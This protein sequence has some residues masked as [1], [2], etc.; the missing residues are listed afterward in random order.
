M[1]TNKILP[2]ALTLFFMMTRGC[3]CPAPT[4]IS[5]TPTQGPGGTIVEVQFDQGGL[6]GTVLWDGSGVT[7]RNAHIVG[8]SHT[9]RFTVPVG[10]TTGNHAVSVQSASKLSNSVDFTV[11][12][13]GNNS[14]PQI[15]GFD[16]AEAGKELTLYG[17]NFTTNSVILVDNV[18]VTSYV[19]TSQ[20]WRTI[21]YEFADNVIVC[22]V[23]GTV[24]P[25]T[26]H[27]AKVVNAPGFESA[28]FTFTVPSRTL[29]TAYTSIAGVPLPQYY[30]SR[31][32]QV[33]SVRR[34]YAE[35]GMA[36]NIVV[37]DTSVTKPAVGGAG[38]TFTDADLYS[39]WR[40]YADT[41]NTGW[42]MLALYADQYSGPGTTW[43]S[44]FMNVS[45]IPGLPAG[46]ERRGYV[47]FRNAFTAA[48]FGTQ[49]EQAYDRDI[50]H[51][52][53]HAFNLFH[54]DTVGS[55]GV[56]AMARSVDLIAAKWNMQYST[57]SKGHIGTHQAVDVEPGQNA[58]G[59]RSC[60]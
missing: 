40:A 13:P 34:S 45:N 29:T 5:I 59:T 55:F 41:A 6:G 8:L 56:S 10:A 2:L 46:R 19:G 4:V 44:M 30:V 22:T 18:T 52:S 14:V 26:S 42:Y 37:H 12:G 3:D 53:G 27:T 24:N 16:V 54:T 57:M 1:K 48:W 7:T 36:L 47:L 11:T 35:A 49:I 9:L 28:I 43:G 25:G 21:P 38:A 58:F 20:P 32:N 17:Q 60:H 33:Y 39:F 51:E 15:D 23:P 31:L 50:L